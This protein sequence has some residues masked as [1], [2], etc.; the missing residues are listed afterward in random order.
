MLNP[1]LIEYYGEECKLFFNELVK[2][3]D[4]NIIGKMLCY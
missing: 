3:V 1:E 4:D 2:R